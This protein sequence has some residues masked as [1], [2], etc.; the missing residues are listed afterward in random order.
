MFFVRM[1]YA[2]VSMTCVCENS[3]YIGEYNIC[4]G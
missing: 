3:L 4:V 1:T 2:L